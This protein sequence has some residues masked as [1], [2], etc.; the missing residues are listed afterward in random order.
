MTG[1]TLG[2]ELAGSFFLPR[3]P[4]SRKTSSYAVLV[5]RQLALEF[6]YHAHN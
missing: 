3:S 2:I 1:E 5:N 4:F 6:R